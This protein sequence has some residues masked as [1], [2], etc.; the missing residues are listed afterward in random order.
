MLLQQRTLLT[1]AKVVTV[2]SKIVTVTTYGVVNIAEELV[3][4][5]KVVAGAR[6]KQQSC[7]LFV[8]I[9]QTNLVQSYLL[10]QKHTY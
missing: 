9:S 8:K 5:A 2:M 4:M 3:L 7:K 1:L 10:T 6:L